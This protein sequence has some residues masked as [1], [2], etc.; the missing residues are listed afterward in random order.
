[1]M[2]INTKINTRINELGLSLDI[3]AEQMGMST[4]KMADKINA[5]GNDNLSSTDLLNLTN[6]LQISNPYKFFYT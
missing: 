3:V 2:D 6:I 5:T 1:M 4:T